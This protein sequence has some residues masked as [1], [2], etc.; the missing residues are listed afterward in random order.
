MFVW[1]KNPALNDYAPIHPRSKSKTFGGEVFIFNGYSINLFFIDWLNGAKNVPPQGDC[2]HS[3]CK[4][5]GVYMEQCN[6]CEWRR[7][8]WNQQEGGYQYAHSGI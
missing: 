1:P 3:E 6:S 4:T 5:W 7:E 2:R 8:C